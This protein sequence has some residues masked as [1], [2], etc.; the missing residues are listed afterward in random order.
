MARKTINQMPTPRWIEKNQHWRM[1]V[2]H[3][4]QRAIMYSSNPSAKFGPAECRAK[5]LAWIEKLE[6]D[7]GTPKV[8]FED[9]WERFLKWYAQ[10]RKITS[11]KQIQNRGKAHLI[12]RFTGRLVTSIKKPEWQQTIF[13][14]YENGAKSAKTLSGIGTT[15]TTFCK[16]CAMRGWIPDTSVP[17]FF[18]IPARATV[19]PKTILQ[20][21]QLALMFD[22]AENDDWYI[23]AYRFIL[24]TGLRRGEF[25]ALQ[26]QRD[27]K[28]G[29]IYVRES[30]SHDLDL[31]DGKSKDAQRSFVPLELAVNELQLHREKRKEAGIKSKYLFC[32]PKGMMI[33]PR[34]LGNNWRK[35]RAKHGLTLTL[36][37]LRHTFISYSRVKTNL[38]LAEFKRIIGYSR[39]MNTDKIYLHDIDKSP[40]ELAAEKAKREQQ[41]TVINTAFSTAIN[42]VAHNVA[43]TISPK[44]E[45]IPE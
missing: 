36:H 20:P 5:Y 24:L 43:K 41:A 19:R 16:F 17:L 6:D 10:R 40:S 11:L 23:H 37:E 28:D 15:I 26:D 18:D 4:G 33:R 27:Y 25:C 44:F 39:E 32:D 45:T 35:W 30:I 38:D 13:D 31:T 9:A 21:D 34:V 42:N 2:R 29:V 22:Q 8:L 3:K 1:D 14:A 7:D 12:K